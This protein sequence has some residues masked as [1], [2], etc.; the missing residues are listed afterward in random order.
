MPIDD[1]P[2]YNILGE[3]ISRN[4]LVNEMIKYYNLKL[5]VGETKVTDFNE[6]SEIRNLLEAIAVDLYV[7]LENVNEVSK[8]AFI[9]TASGEWLDKHGADP[10]INL[11][12]NIGTEAEG[13]VTFSITNERDTDLIIPEATTVTSVENGLDYITDIEAVI[14]VGETETSVGATCLTVGEDGNCSKETITIINDDYFYD[15]ELRVINNDAFENG[16][17]YE[18][19]EEYRQKLLNYIRIDDFGSVPYYQN[20]GASVN[21]VHDVKLVDDQTYT[22][23]VLV[24][25]NEKPVSDSVL[26]DVLYIF[27]DTSNIVMGHSFIVDAPDYLTVDLSI[28]LTI[29][30]EI[31]EDNITEALQAFVDGGAAQDGLEYDGLN[32]GQGFSNVDIINLLMVYNSLI[33]ATVTYDEESN[34][35]ITPDSDEVIKLGTLTI[36]QTVEE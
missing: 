3:E 22:S 27:T 5:G 14:P 25:G 15:P 4:G 31:D 32:I 30:S 6:G 20:L 7:L 12:R 10:R 23:K 21:G 18:E 26:N 28:D 11:P 2:F 36:N 1:T 34:F 9:E 29:S 35:V 19:D 8:V 13:I 24:N 16:T 33:S 17:E